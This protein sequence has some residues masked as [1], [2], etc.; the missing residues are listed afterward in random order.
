MRGLCR[1]SVTLLA[2]ATLIVS[3][4]PS[5]KTPSAPSTS[6]TTAAAHDTGPTVVT[7]L[8]ASVIA[9]PIPVP[10][11]DGKV[12]LAYEL[13]LTNVLNQGLT[14][15]SV[16]VRAGDQTLLTWQAIGSPTGR[17][18]W[19]IPR[20]QRNSGRHSP[21][22]YGLTSRWTG[23]Q[24]SQQSWCTGSGSPWRNRSPRCFP[25]R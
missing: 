19:E 12:H 10:A 16:D 1:T 25:P 4:A 20:P 14:L 9:A 13:L 24:P 8:L 17:V 11:T 2:I 6:T 18:R 3:C 21:R 22:P 23:A 5:S 15:T 7:P